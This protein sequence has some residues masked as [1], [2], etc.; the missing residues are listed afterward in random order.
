MLNSG[1]QFLPT[2]IL[3][4]VKDAEIDGITE[5]SFVFELG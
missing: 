3:I 4:F 1:R 5:L 2:A